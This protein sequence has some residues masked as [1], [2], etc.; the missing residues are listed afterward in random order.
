MYHARR[1]RRGLALAAAVAEGRQ[2][3]LPSPAHL[4]V[5]SPRGA[6]QAS[7]PA[8]GL[9]RWHPAGRLEAPARGEAPASESGASKHADLGSVAACQTRLDRAAITL[10]AVGL[11]EGSTSCVAAA[12]LKVGLNALSAVRRT[13]HASIDTEREACGSVATEAACSMRRFESAL[14][15]HAAAATPHL[16]T[17]SDTAPHIVKGSPT[18]EPENIH[19]LL[20]RVASCRGRSTFEA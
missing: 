20:W 2:G 10:P 11:L 1:P 12:A 17:A 3:L 15:A 9:D 13:P 18:E 16:S 8:Q 7:L 19:F 6:A 5:E 4:L 14:G